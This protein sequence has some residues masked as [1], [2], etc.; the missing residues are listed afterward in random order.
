MAKH[1]DPICGMPVE[2]GSAAGEAEYRGRRY[3]FCSGGC[4]ERFNEDPGRYA[5]AGGAEDKHDEAR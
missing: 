3:Y 2:E 1:T 4:R 5:A